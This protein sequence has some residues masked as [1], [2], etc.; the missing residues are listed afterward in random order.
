MPLST[1]FVAK[2]LT[3]LNLVLNCMS[4]CKITFNSARDSK[5]YCSQ[6]NKLTVAMYCLKQ[7][8]FPKSGYTACF[9]IYPSVGH[10]DGKKAIYQRNLKHC[11]SQSVVK[12]ICKDQFLS[13]VDFAMHNKA[14]PV[15]HLLNKWNLFCVSYIRGTC[16]ALPTFSKLLLH[17]VIFRP[18]SGH[19]NSGHYYVSKD[20]Q[21]THQLSHSNPYL[22]CNHQS[23]KILLGV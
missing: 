15:L 11:W 22:E 16:L 19:A 9:I 23:P 5:D 13:L 1:T 17:E 21:I 8:G 2:V 6:L 14:E 12:P 20:I 7:Q 4:A 10:V 3:V 18:H